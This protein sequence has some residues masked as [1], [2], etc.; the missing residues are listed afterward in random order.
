M[1]KG[2]E[3]FRE[4]S[5]YNDQIELVVLETLHPRVAQGLDA[6]LSHLIID[7]RHGAVWT[8][9]ERVG[10]VFEYLDVGHKHHSDV[11]LSSGRLVP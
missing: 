6:N 9:C 2:E 7:G 4:A 5:V 10:H 3:A 8:R 1:D 11:W